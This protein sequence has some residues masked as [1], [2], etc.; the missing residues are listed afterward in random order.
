MHRWFIRC[1]EPSLP[2]ALGCRK[3]ATTGVT[4]GRKVQKLYAPAHEIICIEDNSAA[5]VRTVRAVERAFDIL[6]Y[7]AHQDEPKGLS[8]ISRE[9]Q[10][11]KATV[12][13][14]IVT[15]KSRG[16][17]RQ[18]QE[19]RS[20]EVVLPGPLL[21]GGTDPACARCA[22][23]IWMSCRV[24]QRK[25]SALSALGGWSARMSM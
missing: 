21:I 19:S 15:L 13:R 1:T 23:P 4:T 16:L 9:L 17:I 7:I 24:G 14:L 22:I 8:E 3:V 5:R 25:L 18:I 11:D 12:L 2:G 10:L 20:Y 6:I